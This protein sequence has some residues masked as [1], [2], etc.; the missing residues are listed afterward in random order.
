VTNAFDRE[1][2]DQDQRGG[3]D[4]PRRVTRPS[5]DGS[6]HDTR[7]KTIRHRGVSGQRDPPHASRLY[8]LLTRGEYSPP[9]NVDSFATADTAGQIAAR[10]SLSSDAVCFPES[11]RPGPGKLRAKESMTAGWERRRKSIVLIRQQD[12]RPASDVERMRFPS[13]RVSSPK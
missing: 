6:R 1:R 12:L 9:R 5:P 7:G 13:F 11:V 4:V 3:G 8:A 2:N 10:R